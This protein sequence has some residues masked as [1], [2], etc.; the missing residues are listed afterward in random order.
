M[1]CPRHTV[2]VFALPLA[3]EHSQQALHFGIAAMTDRVQADLLS[4]SSAPLAWAPVPAGQRNIIWLGGMAEGACA[5]LPV[6][7]WGGTGI[8]A[9]RLTHGRCGAVAPGHAWLV[10]SRRRILIRSRRRS[11]WGRGR[12]LWLVTSDGRQEH[13]G[14]REC[15]SRGGRRLAYC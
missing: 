1:H 3:L 14:V 2:I 9:G 4:C 11:H 5:L 8:R 7:V 10:H 13:V 15:L 12:P 6:S